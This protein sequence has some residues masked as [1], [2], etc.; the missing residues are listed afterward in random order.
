MTATV[1]SNGSVGDAAWVSGNTGF[2]SGHFKADFTMAEFSDATLPNVTTWFTPMG[3]TAPDG[4]YYNNLLPGGNYQVAD[5]SGSVYVG[6]TNTVLYVTGN[7]SV[8]GNGGG[9]KKGNAPAEIHI[10]PGASLTLYM[11]GA[12]TTISGN[13][14]VNDTGRASAFAYYGLPTNTQITL[15]GNGAF[16]GTI[17]APEADFTL[18]GS[19]KSSLDDFT[20][21]SIT[22][23]TTM[24]GNFNFHYDES[25]IRITTLGGYD[26]ISW[27]EL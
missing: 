2:E 18:K 11:A 13:G 22:K 26:P 23:T 27:A 5:L 1:G 21:A 9:T 16:Y 24:S 25:L 15:T 8:G 4:L 10:G 17:Y 14:V 19:G 6:G 7:I 20:G 3:G 12:S